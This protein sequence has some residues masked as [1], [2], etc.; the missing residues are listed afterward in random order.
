MLTIEK[1][2][3]AL[4]SLHTLSHSIDILQLIEASPL[5]GKFKMDPLSISEGLI[6]RSQPH[7]LPLRK[8]CSDSISWDPMMSLVFRRKVGFEIIWF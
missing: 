4:H 5:E 1:A 7:W 2:K 3:Q 8:F 6:H